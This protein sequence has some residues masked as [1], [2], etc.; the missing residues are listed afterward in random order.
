MKIMALLPPLVAVAVAVI[1][2]GYMRVLWTT[3]IGWILIAIALV[4]M[5]TGTVIARKLVKIDV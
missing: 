4:L 1:N 5:T 2:P 3:R